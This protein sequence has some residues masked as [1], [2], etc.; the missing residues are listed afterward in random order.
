MKTKTLFTLFFLIFLLTTSFAQTKIEGLLIDSTHNNILRSATV[1]VYEQGKKSVDKVTLTDR[2]GKFIIDD[3][4]PNKSMLIEFSFQGFEKS[5]RE[6]M[7]KQGEHLNFGSINM[8]LS[9][10][11]IEEV[12]IIPPV[13]MNG[14]TIEFNADA[15]ELDSNAVIED[16]LHKLPGLIVWGDG[17]VTYNG[18]EVPNVLVNG[19]SFFGSDKVIVLQNID[20]K[21]V[22]KIQ[23]YDSRDK[24]KQKEDPHNHQY[25]MNVVLK[26]GSDKMYFGNAGLGGGTKDHYQAALNFN[27]STKKH[28]LQLHIAPTMSTKICKM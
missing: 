12:S 2:F 6:F 17:A 11:E 25:E 3:I 27:H 14:D 5:V 16:L 15:F 4:S 8:Q 7:L 10:L 19:K 26:E 1:S 28:R 24:E 22:D 13:R 9:S 21:A 20:K 18:K 23:I